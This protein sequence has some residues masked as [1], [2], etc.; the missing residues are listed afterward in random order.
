MIGDTSLMVTVQP[1][2]EF[3][4]PDNTTSHRVKFVNLPAGVTVTPNDLVNG[5]PITGLSTFSLYAGGTAAPGAFVLRVEKSNDSSVN[6]QQSV[7]IYRTVSQFTLD[8]PVAP[9]TG[10]AGVPF[11]VTVTARDSFGAVVRA[12]HDDVDVSAAVGDSVVNGGTYISG[13]TFVN[14]VSAAT[15]TLLG[16]TIGSL[17]NT[18]TAT[19][20]K[21]YPGQGTLSHGQVSVT[22]EPNVF[23]HILLTFPGETL[24]PGTGSGK[25]GQA[26]AATAGVPIVGVSAWLEDQY[27]NPVRPDRNPEPGLYP[28]TVTYVS[29]PHPAKSPPATRTP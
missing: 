6:G 13:A 7:T 10:K 8:P 26:S 11:L 24:T 21:L 25:T 12:F 4:N 20:R 9:F 3:G 28:V 29:V 18:I 15:V 1:L 19:A 16:T 5:T 27:N 2:D 22:I 17:D 14:G 23:D